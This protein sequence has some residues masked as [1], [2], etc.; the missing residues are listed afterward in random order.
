LQILFVPSLLWGVVISLHEEMGALFSL[1]LGE[2]GEWL[3]NVAEG[4]FELVLFALFLAGVIYLFYRF[5]LFL[6]VPESVS[7]AWIA[8][9][10][11]AYAVIIAVVL[12]VVIGL[13]W[14][15]FVESGQ[16]PNN[17]QYGM[18]TISTAFFG[19]VFLTPLCTVVI[20]WFLALRK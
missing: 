3:H 18:A 20:V 9:R 10:L 14:W 8:I 15:T 6:I 19:S 5:P 16:D 2:E 7:L 13:G 12:A 17:L 1:I 4:A 11:I